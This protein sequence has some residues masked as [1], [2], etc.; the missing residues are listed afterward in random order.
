M[1]AS[2]CTRLEVKRQQRA[3]VL[4]QH[5]AFHARLQRHLLGLRVVEGNAGVLLLVIQKAEFHGD[6]Q[7]AAHF[8]VNRRDR[9]L[10][11][12]ESPAKAFW[13]S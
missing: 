1:T 13:R 11:L 12:R 6:A 3:L 4:Q 5:H 8:V 7:K 10:A 2:V 9:N